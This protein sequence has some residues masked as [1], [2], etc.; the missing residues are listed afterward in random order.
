MQ[1][2][3]QSRSPKK[4]EPKS[5]CNINNIPTEIITQILLFYLRISWGTRKY[6]NCSS[7]DRQPRSCLRDIHLTCKRWRDIIASTPDFWAFVDI[8]FAPGTPSLSLRKL[9]KWLEQSRQLPLT[10]SFEVQAP[11]STAAMAT[12]QNTTS[13][14]AALQRLIYHLSR[15]RD[16]SL[17]FPLS[18]TPS[19]ELP[20]LPTTGGSKTAAILESLSI[21]I[22]G[23]GY[24]RSLQWISSL[25][26]ISPHLRAFSDGGFTGLQVLPLHLVPLSQLREISL[27]RAWSPHQALQ[28]LEQ[29][30]MLEWCRLSLIGDSV[31]SNTVVVHPPALNPMICHARSM[32]LSFDR[33]GPTFFTHL[34]APNLTELSYHAISTQPPSFHQSLLSFLTRT[35]GQITSFTIR[36]L[37]MQDTELLE[38]LCILSPSLEKLAI[39]TDSFQSPIDYLRVENFSEDVVAAL[40][41]HGERRLQVSLDGEQEEDL[42]F[43]LKLQVLI[44]ERCVD[45]EDG[46]ISDMVASRRSHPTV[47]SISELSFFSVIFRYHSHP[48]DYER[49]AGMRR[50]GLI[51]TTKFGCPHED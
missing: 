13:P 12:G 42:L 43:C 51:G 37:L 45:V 22:S 44:L 50:K 41:Y 38:L 24:H 34:V 35:H 1:L 17:T 2:S 30:P 49:L 31:S 15:W 3:V 14:G 10:I 18:L 6:T 28:I 5:T 29:M 16:V 7:V 47:N 33:S 21:N 25:L 32:T 8:Q 23:L 39:L 40:T 9:D 4:V 46:L 11:N 20:I 26:A 48:L 19:S 27:D 36:N